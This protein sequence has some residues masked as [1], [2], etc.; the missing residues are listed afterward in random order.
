MEPSTIIGTA[1]VSLLLIAYFLNLFKIVSQ[2]SLLYILL[3]ILGAAIA[4]VA[5][6]LIDFVPFIVLEIIWVIVGFAGIYSY[7]RKKDDD[8]D[9]KIPFRLN[10]R[11]QD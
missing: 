11:S 1:G 5:S 2:G 3:N 9:M 8:K 6:V 7:F 10:L 4:C